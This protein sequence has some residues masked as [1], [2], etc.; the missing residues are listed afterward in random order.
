MTKFDGLQIER[1]GYH[2]AVSGA[3]WSGC[4]IAGACVQAEDAGEYYNPSPFALST[5]GARANSTIA[6]RQ[7]ARVDPRHMSAN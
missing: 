2:Y 1:D 4:V 3:D 6:F 5:P 7:R